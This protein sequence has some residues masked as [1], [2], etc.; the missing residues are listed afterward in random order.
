MFWKDFIK[1]W[2]L[3]QIKKPATQIISARPQFVFATEF[4]IS[5]AV[6]PVSQSWTD[7]W[8]ANSK[9]QVVEAIENFLKD[10]NSLEDFV[11]KN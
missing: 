3:S 7:S 5:L 11:T 9:A 2:Q 6:D 4:H 10:Y 1:K 8:C